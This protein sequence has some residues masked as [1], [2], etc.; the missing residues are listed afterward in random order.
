MINSRRIED[1]NI[2]LQRGANEFLERCKKAGLNPIITQ[3]LRDKEYQDFLY[4]KGR[5]TKG[6]IVTNARGGTSFHNYGL[7]FDI[8][9][10]E[11]GAE[12]S[13]DSFFEKAGDIWTEMGG[14][15]GGNFKSIK[16]KP[17][18]EFSAE[19][20]IKDLQS[21]K[22]LDKN[23]KMKWEEEMEKSEFVLS[24]INIQYGD[25]TLGLEAI[26]YGKQN[27]IKIR[28]VEQFGLKVKYDSKTKIISIEK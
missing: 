23:K 2:V 6:E 28:D 8:C 24:N 22:K 20:T 15:W 16:D 11:K 4:S 14:V 3:T 27:Y 7:A 9:K 26:N 25:E 17:H 21:G 18:F 5:T 13:D 10:N 19:L 1:L 12:Y